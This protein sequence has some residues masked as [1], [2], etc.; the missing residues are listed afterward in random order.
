VRT[1][2]PGH[3]AEAVAD[4]LGFLPEASQVVAHVAVA[5]VRGTPLWSRVEPSLAKQAEEVFA[6]FRLA[7]GFD[8][9]PQV[10]RVT[11]GLR[12]DADEP[13]EG[14]VV[15]GGLGRSEVMGC[16]ARALRTQP[17]LGHIERGVVVLDRA[18][19]PGAKPVAF[20]FAASHTLVIVFGPAATAQGVRGVLDSGA[21][22]RKS[23][24]FMDLYTREETGHHAWFYGDATA[25]MFANLAMLGVQARA[26]FGVVDAPASVTAKL[27]LRLPTAA[28]ATTL[29]GKA[30]A[31]FTALKSFVEKLEARADDTDLIVDLV[32]TEQQ[33][34]LG[35]S[36]IP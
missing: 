26:M 4:P 19:L 31:Q 30:Q 11:F 35:G 32:L 9:S 1:A 27:V 2:A 28:D 25:K 16:V 3:H 13:T 23:A 34:S 22:L 6:P 21:P 17:T 14:V 20:A 10:E 18:R 15:V 36:L 12:G 7:C 33:L 5:A 24:R 8:P 29:V